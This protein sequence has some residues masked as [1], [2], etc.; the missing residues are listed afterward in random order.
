MRL[1]NLQGDFAAQ[2]WGNALVLF[3]GEHDAHIYYLMCGYP[4]TYIT[5]AK[6]RQQL[7]ELVAFLNSPIPENKSEWN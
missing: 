5:T 1:V 2:V 3:Y 7:N 4:A 6:T